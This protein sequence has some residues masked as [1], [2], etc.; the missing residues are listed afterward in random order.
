MSDHSNIPKVEEVPPKKKKNNVEKIIFLVILSILLLLTLSIGAF[1]FRYPEISKATYNFIKAPVSQVSSNNNK[2]NILLMGK[3]GENH[4]GADLTDTMMLVS[5]PLK[6]GEIK[7]VS[8]P[9]DVWVPELMAKINSAYYWGKYGSAYFSLQDTGGGISFA[10]RIV[11]KIIG[12]PIQYGVVIDFSAFK[13]IVDAVGGISVDVE[14]P[15]VDNFYPIEGRENDLCGG[16][17]SFS[18]RYETVI[19]DSGVQTMDGA[20]ALKFV[21]S[22]HA[23]GDEGTDIARESRQQKVI[24]AIKDKIVEPKTYLSTK[25]ISALLTI[26]NKYIETDINLPTVG[27]IVRKGLENMNNISQKRFPEN[28]VV[29]P[30]TNPIYDNLY[31]FIPK[32]GNGNW[33]EI[34]KWF[35]ENF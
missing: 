34:Q 9:R 4:D 6:D 26:A 27:I 7:T 14:H 13:D 21:R 10:K 28:L 31:V 25:R 33:E 24:A 5:I 16:D 8:I 19:F 12:Q 20:T 3:S 11:G 15:F 29:V 22:R 1:L 30:K 18:C 17:K 2:I 35:T 23:E 32:A